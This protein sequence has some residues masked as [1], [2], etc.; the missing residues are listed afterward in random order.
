VLS[1][2]CFGTT[3][4]RKRGHIK[5]LKMVCSSAVANEEFFFH[6]IFSYLE[7]NGSISTQKPPE[8]SAI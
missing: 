4:D 2:S 7:R 8:S 1:F 5:L 3:W 6:L